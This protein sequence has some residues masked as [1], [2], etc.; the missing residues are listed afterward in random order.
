MWLHHM[1]VMLM[2]VVATRRSHVMVHVP[3]LGASSEYNY[4]V[5]RPTIFWTHFVTQFFDSMSAAVS[6]AN[7]FFTRRVSFN[8]LHPE[9]PIDFTPRSAPAPASSLFDG[10]RLP[11]HT[12]SLSSYMSNYTSAPKKRMKLPDAPSKSILKN[13]LSPQQLQYN[14]Q[15]SK[16]LGINYHGDLNDMVE[17]DKEETKVPSG[18]RKSYSG[19]TDEELLALDPQFQTTKSKVGR[20][21]DFK[22]DSQSTYYLPQKRQLVSTSAIKSQPVYPL[23]NENNYK[24]ISLTVKHKEFDKAAESFTRTLVTVVSG[25]RH[26]W[27]SLDWLLVT[28][29]EDEPLFLTDGDFLVVTALIPQKF[30]KEHENKKKPTM[31]EALYTK[32][33]ALLAYILDLLPSEL[34]LKIT[35]EFVLD[36]P[37][38]EKVTGVKYML[39]H[40]FK[41]Y[42]PTLL[43]VGNRSTNLNFKYPI[44]MNR[45]M[46][47]TEPEF[48][49]A[50]EAS[51]YL[52]KLSSY[53]IK[54][55]TVPVIVVGNTTKYHITPQTTKPQ[56]LVSFSAFQA[57]TISIIEP[58]KNSSASSDSESIESFAPPTPPQV[59]DV[60]PLLQEQ[61]T[62]DKFLGVL[63]A[64]SQNSLAQ[65]NHYLSVI[66][67]GDDG[68]IVVGNELINSSVHQLYKS[69]L[70]TVASRRGSTT[71]LS[72]GL[73]AGRTQLSDRIYK[74]KSLIS[75]NEEDEKKNEQ[76]LTTKR[77]KKISSQVSTLSNNSNGSDKKKKKSFFQ[78]IGLKK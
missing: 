70:G 74:V 45:S 7:N 61:N 27:N 26:T 62:E 71:R 21:E 56:P 39:S 35:V 59:V 15:N 43:V 55:S 31:D 2:R 11:S 69:Q 73:A 37:A 58:T 38:T 22:F 66:K 9:D 57:P 1:N 29:V 67:Q 25:R 64:V 34:R 40:I 6:N 53:V 49:H 60:K 8:N 51:H 33:Q 32:C 16:S 46:S 23:S 76:M 28:N 10:P 5:W 13:K 54:Y 14:L 75:Y 20:M 24:L 36:V 72:V 50:P 63:S 30:V 52:I 77:I 17:D 12:V 4:P 47:I 19:M 65:C 41:Q 18:R 3:C 68:D 78:K 44:K 42:Q 48:G